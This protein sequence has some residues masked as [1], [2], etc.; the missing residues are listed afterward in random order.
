VTANW[1]LPVARCIICESVGLPTKERASMGITMHWSHRIWPKVDTRLIN[2]AIILQKNRLT[3]SKKRREKTDYSYK[4][5]EAHSHTGAEP[6]LQAVCQ[7]L[8]VMPALNDTKKLAQDLN[9]SS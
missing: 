6:K 3:N 1:F 4:L 2:L 8:H 5:D 7:T 9:A